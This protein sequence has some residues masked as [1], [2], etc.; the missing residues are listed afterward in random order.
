MQLQERGPLTSGRQAA[1]EHENRLAGLTGLAPDRDQ[2]L[3]VA[4]ALDEGGDDP[5]VRIVDERGDDF[6]RSDVE[7]ASAAVP[8][9]DAVT[10]RDEYSRDRYSGSS[11]F[12]RRARE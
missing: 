10:G 6:Q 4:K 8:G 5:G 2:L 3:A 11:G 7:L 12:A 1:L 9:A